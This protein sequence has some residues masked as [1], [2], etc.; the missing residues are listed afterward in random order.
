MLVPRA[1]FDEVGGLDEIRLA[2]AFNDVDFCLKIREAGHRLVWTPYAELYHHESVSRG[3]DTDPEKADRF[4]AEVRVMQER[5]STQFEV[6]P[7]Y[8]P[9]LTQDREHPVIADPPR[10]VKPWTA[11]FEE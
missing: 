4:S 7:F 6:D 5:W 2:V 1:V 11:Y 3:L 10:S 9:N 8:S